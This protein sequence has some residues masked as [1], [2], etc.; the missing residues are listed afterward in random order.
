MLSHTVYRTFDTACRRELIRITDDVAGIV[1]E[2]AVTE[3][4]VLVCAIANSTAAV[5]SAW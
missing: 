2:S 1:R 5:A 4:M 3:G